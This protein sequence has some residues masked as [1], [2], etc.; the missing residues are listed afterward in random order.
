MTKLI[1][2]LGL[3]I[4]LSALNACQSRLFSFERNDYARDA[5]VCVH[6]PK[7]MAKRSTR[8]VVDP[9]KSVAKIKDVDRYLIPP[10]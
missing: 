9:Y 3:F 5:D 1:R 7:D 8:Y 6:W 2:F 4:L 10:K